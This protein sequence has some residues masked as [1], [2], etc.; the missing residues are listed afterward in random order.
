MD[1]QST[2][3]HAP[4][5]VVAIPTFK[6]PERLAEL[7][8]NVGAQ[9]A[10]LQREGIISRGGIVVVDNDGAGSARR[11]V[12]PAYSDM[13]ARYAVETTKGI[14][15]VRNRALDESLDFELLAFI[16]DDELPLEGWLRSLVETYTEFGRPAAVMGRVVSIFAE[17]VD[18][19]VTATGLFQRPQRET[20]TEISVAATGNLLLDLDQVRAS[21]VRFDESIGLGGGSDT[22]FSMM[23][24]R[25]GARMVWCNE[26]VTEDTVEI[27]RQTRAWALKR[28]YSHGNVATRVRLQLEANP[29]VRLILRAKGVAGGAG[30]VVVGVLRHL[31]GRVTR[32]MGHSA[33]GL[34][35]A[36]RGAGMVAAAGGRSYAAYAGAH[37]PATPAPSA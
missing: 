35:L 26:S 31:L 25:T 6:R 20:G 2:T 28:A 22:L 9:L 34:R 29:R 5:I 32:S 12:E 1:A 30:R 7:L 36:Y 21:G 23:L 16:D 27:E 10:A 15:A 19:W 37:A 13:P 11:V 8:P 14:P 18:P 33:R 24:K 4:S 17:D 3:G